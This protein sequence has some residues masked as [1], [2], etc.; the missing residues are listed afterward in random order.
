MTI[1]K[2]KPEMS[3]GVHALDSDHK[4]LINLINQLDAAIKDGLGRDTIESVLSTLVDYT[5]Y[6]F[7]REEMLMQACGYSDLAKHQTSHEGMKTWVREIKSRFNDS[8]DDLSTEVLDFL[9]HWLT[10]HI[11]VQDQDYRSVMEGKEYEIARANR[12]FA[13]N[14]AYANIGSADEEAPLPF[15]KDK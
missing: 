13:E 1:I 5:C 10:D 11:M 3:V 9:Q 4:L 12:E 7:D 2:W 15:P 6:H 14:Y 8:T